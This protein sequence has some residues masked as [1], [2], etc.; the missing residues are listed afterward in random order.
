VVLEAYFLSRGM[1]LAY[2]SMQSTLQEA[3][4]NVGVD[5]FFAA[6]AL[7]MRKDSVGFVSIFQGP[8]GSCTSKAGILGRGRMH[9]QEFD[10]RRRSIF[11]FARH[12]R[13]QQYEPLDLALLHTFDGCLV[14]S[15][16][17]SWISVSTERLDY[18]TNKGTT[19]R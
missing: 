13:M 17:L 5:L 1:H 18:L 7:L 4:D 19:D 3:L 10:G 15:R 8:T 2:V 14:P 11:R 9:T 12:F 6:M 16:L